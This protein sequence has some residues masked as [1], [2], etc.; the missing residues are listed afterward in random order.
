MVSLKVI[1]LSTE[2]Q[3]HEQTRMHS[4]RMHSVCTSNRLPGGGC[5][6]QGGAC[7]RGVPAPG[8]ACSQGG[9]VSQHALRQTPH[10]DRQT[11][12]KT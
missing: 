9:W 11:G 4:S 3:T 2:H 1:D 6:L 7:S 12:V 5:L 10:V 8:G